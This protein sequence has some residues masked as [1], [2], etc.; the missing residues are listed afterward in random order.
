MEDTK[1]LDLKKAVF[2]YFMSWRVT[3]LCIVLCVGLLLGYTYVKPTF[4]NPETPKEDPTQSEKILIEKKNKFLK[5]DAEAKE[6]NAQIL[7]FEKEIQA[8]DYQLSN[9]LL[10]QIDPNKR[11]NK[12]FVLK[13]SYFMIDFK[14]KEE[15]IRTNQMLSLHYMRQLSGDRYLKYLAGKGIIKYNPEHIANLV[16]VRI[17]EE[18]LIAFEITGPEE[19][20]IDQFIKTTKEY[21]EKIIRPEI[22]LLAAYFLH[23]TDVK[24]DVVRDPSIILLKSKIENEISLK[25][26]EIET[27]TKSID[28]VF[29]EVLK[30]ES[31]NQDNKTSE[32][33]VAPR[34]YKRNLVLGV[35][36]GI[37]LSVVIAM[38]RFRHKIAM[39]DVQQIALANGI[40]YLGVVPYREGDENMRK[41]RLGSS[42]DKWFIKI[43][44]MAYD[45]DKA[46]RSTEYVA[47]IL[48]GNA[49]GLHD[50]DAELASEAGRTGDTLA[51]DKIC[52]IYVPNTDK[53]ETLKTSIQKLQDK[54][55]N[56]TGEQTNCIRLIAGGNLENDPQAIDSARGSNGLLLISS[57]SVKDIDLANSL[58]ISWNLAKDVFG[59]VELQER[60]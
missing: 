10:L 56:L 41:R 3:I 32:S 26:G 45:E 30:A 44:G 15:E 17:S 47:Q 49:E 46:T 38:V 11:I 50:Q 1:V 33:A 5:E 2:Y 22:D 28:D 21:L 34:S 18:G 53:S 43:F 4:K 60:F 20:I 48:M 14:D 57:P 12:S 25:K 37:F 24:K 19:I 59:I 13:Y 54:L 6:L 27:L 51:G 55:D 39:I 36:L 7:G 58:Q 42:I 40:A 29:D 23:F 9:N 16:D 31:E 8:L 52:Q 35:L